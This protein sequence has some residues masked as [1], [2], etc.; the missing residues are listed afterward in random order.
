M[1]SNQPVKSA[2][3]PIAPPVTSIAAAKPPSLPAKPSGLE[4]LEKALVGK[5]FHFVYARGTRFRAGKFEGVLAETHFTVRYFAIADRQLQRW[6]HVVRC[7]TEP[8]I[9][10]FKGGRMSFA[11]SPS[12]QLKI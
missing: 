7:F 10:S 12:L 4:R 3:R 5:F 6:T 11:F 2:I 1:E 9:V 8:S